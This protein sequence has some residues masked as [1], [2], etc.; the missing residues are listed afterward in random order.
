MISEAKLEANR[1]NAQ[2]STGPKTDEGKATVSQNA[3]K[4][5]LYKKDIYIRPDEKEAFEEFRYNLFEEYAPVGVSEEAAFARILHADWSLRRIRELEDRLF[6]EFDDPFADPE[7]ERR[8]N[9]YAR[10]SGRFERM[11]RNAVKE[12]R[13]LQH[14]RATLSLLSDDE[15]V[16]SKLMDTEK[17]RKLTQREELHQARVHKNHVDS[18]FE[19]GRLGKIF[20]SPEFQ[21]HLNRAYEEDLAA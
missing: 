14:D 6:F 16:H 9:A 3:V 12:L 17:L 21:E 2:H 8:M 10:H 19:D 13:K 20:A 18:L 15:L 1:A 7:A 11:H 4:H 5:G